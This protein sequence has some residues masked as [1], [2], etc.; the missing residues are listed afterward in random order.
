M[1]WLPWLLVGCEGN[2]PPRPWYAGAAVLADPGD[3]VLSLRY[4]DGGELHV[5]AVD[6]GALKHGVYDPADGTVAWGPA[7][8]VQRDGQPWTVESVVSA[9]RLHLA[10]RPGTDEIWV[11]YDA[12]VGVLGDDGTV[13]VRFV[14]PEG[15]ASTDLREGALAFV[16]GDTLLLADRP[17]RAL[18]RA[19]VADPSAQEDLSTGDVQACSLDGAGLNATMRGCDGD[20]QRAVLVGDGPT[21]GPETASDDGVS[22]EQPWLGGAEAYGVAN[23][24]TGGICVGPSSESGHVRVEY[25]NLEH[26][27]SSC[28]ELVTPALVALDGDVRGDG[29]QLAT[30]VGGSPGFL[31]FDREAPP[32]RERDI[33]GAWCNGDRR[34]ELLDGGEV[35]LPYDSTDPALFDTITWSHDGQ[36]LT[37]AY[38]DPTA[39]N[40]LP[41]DEPTVLYWAL[42]TG[43]LLHLGG[44]ARD[45]LD[46]VARTGLTGLWTPCQ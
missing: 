26:A 13:D 27:F 38:R 20:Q 2:A 37:L 24:T 30:F 9:N 42:R 32:T 33:A 40:I 17:T 43:D 8:S 1:R 39:A 16:D 41:E 28:T 5:L 14:F 7:L 36:R 34:L 21:A 31:V 12:S 10:P 18:V 45:H 35:V 46:N 11:K 29:D 22:Y 15:T 4:D 19:S 6:G 3:L 23:T 44:F 25:L